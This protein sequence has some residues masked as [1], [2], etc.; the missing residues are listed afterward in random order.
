[1]K[2]Y[3]FRLEPVL[4]VRRMQEEAARAVLLAATAAAADQE[5]QLAARSEAYEKACLASEVRSCADF[6]YEQSRRSAFAAAVLEQRDRVRAAQEDVVRARS[7]WSDT[8]SRVG[9]L[10][11]LDDRQRDEHR[12]QTQKEDDL[13]T[14]ELVVAR[15][16]RDDR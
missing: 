5:Q 2:R 3:R 15:F 12:M 8:A 13:N 6:L 10:E 11:R 4:R 16:G 9:A 1:V 7:A 14:D